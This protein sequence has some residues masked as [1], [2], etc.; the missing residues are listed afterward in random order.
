MI[1]RFILHIIANALAILAAEW[2]VPGVTFQYEFLSLIKIALMLALV[3]A[4]LKPVIK[5][6]AGPL[7]LLTL[8]LFTLIINLFLIWLVVYFAPELSISGLNAYFWTMIIVG[9]F[10]FVVSMTAKDA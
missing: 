8:G 9:V 1:T 3:N 6:I 5:L 4:F 7:I 10:N 2:L